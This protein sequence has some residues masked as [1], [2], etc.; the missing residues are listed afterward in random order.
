MRKAKIITASNMSN[1]TYSLLCDGLKKVIGEDVEF[2]RSINNEI[3]GGFVL[4]IDGTL[5]DNSIKAQLKELK[6]HIEK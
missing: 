6:K 1:E 2:V 4:K 5:Y 3:L